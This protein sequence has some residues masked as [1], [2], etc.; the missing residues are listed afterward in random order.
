VV[1]KLTGW[2]G[3]PMNMPHMGSTGITPQ[4]GVTWTN[5]PNLRELSRLGAIN[6]NSESSSGCPMGGTRGWWP[7]SVTVPADWSALNVPTDV[8]CRV[9]RKAMPLYR[10][11]GIRSGMSYGCDDGGTVSTVVQGI[12]VNTVARGNNPPVSERSNQLAS[13]LVV[14][15]WW[16]VVPQVKMKSGASALGQPE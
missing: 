6:K 15:V 12:T 3:H 9:S 2:I 1:I 4:R 11:R 10:H 16:G 7:A 13:I 8:Y 14:V 5:A